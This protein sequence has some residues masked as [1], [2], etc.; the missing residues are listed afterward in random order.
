MNLIVLQN[1]LGYSFKD[2]KLLQQALTHRS[3]S[4]VHNERLE[5]LGDSILNCVIALIL[6]EKYRKVNEG[7][8]SYLRAG[9]IRQ[10]S[11]Y[12]IAIHLNLSRFLWLGDG[13]LQSGGA[14]RP[15]ILANAVEAV[16][17]AIFL[18]AN[19]NVIR[20]IIDSL[21]VSVLDSLNPNAIYKDPKTLLQEYLQ[22]K[23]LPLPQYKVVAKYGT[24]HN[25][26]FKIQCSVPKFKV[27]FL[28][29][30]NNRRVAEQAAAKLCLKAIK[31]DS[32]LYHM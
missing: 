19:F 9:L 7:N 28:G 13:E 15:S 24:A 8:L 18:D 23:Q 11:L 27:Q 12:K 3:Y 21:Y 6:F 16:F 32:F 26:E 4:S 22:S 14:Y 17:G 31:K 10:H 30:G 5:F 29:I 1:S 25:Q 20:Q 2:L